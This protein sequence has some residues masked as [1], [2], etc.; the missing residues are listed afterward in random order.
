MQTSKLQKKSFTKSF[1]IYKNIYKSE[2]QCKAIMQLKCS[3]ISLKK[4]TIQLK[5]EKQKTKS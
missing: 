2:V 3:W 1:T 5:I 4:K